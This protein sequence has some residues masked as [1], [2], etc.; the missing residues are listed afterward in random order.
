MLDYPA[1][2]CT[3]YTTVS[4]DMWD[5]IAYKVYGPGSETLMNVLL[6]WNPA[7]QRIVVFDAGAQI[8]V[9]QAV[10]STSLPSPPWKTIQKLGG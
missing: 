7:L 10:G 6:D 4:G 2:G 1:S 9:P 5:S 3:Y 8:L